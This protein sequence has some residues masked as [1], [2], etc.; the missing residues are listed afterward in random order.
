MCK[1]HKNMI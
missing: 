1:T